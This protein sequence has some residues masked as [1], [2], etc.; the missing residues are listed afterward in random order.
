M[1]KIAIGALMV[2][3]A[4]SQFTDSFESDPNAID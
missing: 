1:K 3:A 2:Y 4:M